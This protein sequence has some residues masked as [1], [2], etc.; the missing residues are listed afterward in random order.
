MLC[1][2]NCARQ[3][4]NE[5]WRYR[6]EFGEPSPAGVTLP[7]RRECRST[8]SNLNGATLSHEGNTG[9]ILFHKAGRR[10]AHFAGRL[11]E[12]LNGL[13][14]RSMGSAPNGAK[15]SH[16]GEGKSVL[17]KGA[18]CRD[19]HRLSRAGKELVVL[20]ASL[21]CPRLGAARAKWNQVGG[22]A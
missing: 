16:E 7:P 19:A 8:G 21:F 2:G 3:I 9:G 6:S 5:I 4:P 18:G 22:D 1:S 20:G 15:I 13:G 10:Y 14:G 12:E 11:G 17:F